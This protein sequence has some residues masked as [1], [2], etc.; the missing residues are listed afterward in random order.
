M[1]YFRT[2]SRPG[3][4]TNPPPPR[5]VQCPPDVPKNKKTNVAFD[6]RVAK[7]NAACYFSFKVTC[8]PKMR[9]NPPA[10]VKVKCW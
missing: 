9:C 5:R 2:T 6:G 7:R 3:V 8:P 1:F 10:P 4:K